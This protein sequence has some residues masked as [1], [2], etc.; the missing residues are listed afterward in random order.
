VIFPHHCTRSP[1]TK[2]RYLP[3][4]TVPTGASQG[5]PLA[6]DSTAPHIQWDVR[7]YSS[8]VQGSEPDPQNHLPPVSMLSK[9]EAT[10]HR[11]PYRHDWTQGQLELCISSENGVALRKC[12]RL[13]NNYVICSRDHLNSVNMPNFLRRRVQIVTAGIQAASSSNRDGRP[14][15]NYTL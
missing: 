11:P 14:A 15:V 1:G 8:G 2:H 12:A 5:C 10:S 9:S 3:L 6:L 13:T 7:P 4:V